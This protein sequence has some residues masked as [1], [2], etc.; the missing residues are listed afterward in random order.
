MLLQIQLMWLGV[1]DQVFASIKTHVPQLHPLLNMGIQYIWSL[2][3]IG[4]FNTIKFFDHDWTFIKVTWMG[5]LPIKKK[6]IK[7]QEQQGILHIFFSYRV[8]IFG[9]VLTYHWT[10][11]AHYETRFCNYGIRIGIY[12]GLVNPIPTCGG[13]ISKF[14]Y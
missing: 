6:H 5:T 14:P 12:V 3:F 2:V 1:C 7:K 9:K 4:Q 8:L 13:V 10:N 11:G